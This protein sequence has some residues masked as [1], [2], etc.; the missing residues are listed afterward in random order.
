MIAE[1][2]RG[3][4]RLGLRLVFY[5]LL[6]S[7]VISAFASGI[8]LFQNYKQQANAAFGVVERVETS[9][10]K[11]LEYALWHFDF[12][13]VRA[14]LQGIQADKNVGHVLLTSV[15]GHRFEMGDLNFERRPV[16]FNL[17]R[18]D[19]VQRADIGTL[20]INVSFETVWSAMRAQLLT[21]LITNTAKAWLV[22]IAMLLIFR[23][24]VTRHL[25]MIARLVQTAGTSADLLQISLDRPE[26]P[27]PDT[28]SKIIAALNDL[29][30]RS[31][32]SVRQMQI[33]M[34]QRRAAEAEARAAAQARSSFLANM[35]HEIRTPL[36]AMMGLFQLIEM[37]DVPAKQREQARTGI[38]AGNTM[39]DQL[40]NVLEA[41]RLEARAVE[42]A[43]L[44]CAVTDLV[45]RWRAMA[46]GAV[47]RYQ[48]DLEVAVTVSP[49]VPAMVAVD[50]K[51]I[52]QIVLN[53]CDNAAKFT[54]RGRMEIRI[55][56][57]RLDGADCLRVAVSDTGPGIAADQID[58]VFE[59]FTRQETGLTQLKAGTG[60]GLSI[61]RDIAALMDGALTV[62]R[63][64][65]G[66]EWST[67]FI[68]TVPDR[69]PLGTV[70]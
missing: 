21:L 62:E 6:V 60:L 31:S 61:C 9:L 11:P 2:W 57:L 63:Q 42:V 37:S 22:A 4:D 34:D 70:A 45:A 44:D 49:R 15:T 58:R 17:T 32:Q 68:L 54:E 23:R 41:S 56:Y 67:R 16:S 39:L 51:R 20:T 69:I 38:E 28:L 53:L 52:T 29:S 33:E 14:I 12:Q 19:G 43:A 3:A 8:Q 26:P 1:V 40:N 25:R 18:V 27:R 5:T 35:S 65:P 30:E 66:S 36:N 24:L 64:G 13:Q 59:R 47:E 50:G 55:D 48:R 46:L 10:I 7:A